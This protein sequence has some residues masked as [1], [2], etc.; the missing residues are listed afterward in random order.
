MQALF[1]SWVGNEIVRIDVLSTVA[2]SDL[3]ATARALMKEYFSAGTGRV[4][5]CRIY[6]AHNQRLTLGGEEIG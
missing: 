6:L 3:N 1:V 4:D 2:G 5:V